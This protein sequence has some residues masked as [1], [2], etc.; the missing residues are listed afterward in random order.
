[1]A[2]HA[3]FVKKDKKTMLEIS[4]EEREKQQRGA[5]KGGF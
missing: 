4:D 3:D 5:A 2:T 1:M